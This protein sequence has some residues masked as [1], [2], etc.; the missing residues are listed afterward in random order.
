[1]SRRQNHSSSQTLPLT[2]GKSDQNSS[3]SSNS[4]RLHNN[5]NRAQTQLDPLVMVL[6]SHN[7]LSE[8][9]STE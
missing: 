3:Q 7:R 2:N 5:S 4:K 6:L 1:M 8:A 9:H